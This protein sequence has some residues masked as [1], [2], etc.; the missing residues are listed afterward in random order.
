[1]KMSIRDGKLLYHLT[2]IENL[3]SI[4]HN[5]L[6]SRSRVLYF[7][8]VADADIITFRGENGL[9]DLVPFHFFSKNPFD[10]RVQLNDPDR[11]MVYI[12]VDRAFAQRNNFKIL[13]KHPIAL[14][15]SFHLHD[16]D[17]GMELIDWDVMD[18][19]NYSDLECKHICMAE[20]LSD[21][22]IEPK[23][24]RCIFVKDEETKIEVEGMARTILTNPSF[25]VRS[26]SNMFIKV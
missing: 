26:N 23:D 12:C 18:Q 16:Y 4:L 3:N 17:E 5:G 21:F 15:D 24:F 20:C 25:F 9:N 2:S 14:G 8:D 1:M 11:N 19:R 7:Q 10:G 22:T 6:L 13:T